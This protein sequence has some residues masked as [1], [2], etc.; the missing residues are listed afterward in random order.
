GAARSAVLPLHGQGRGASGWQ[1]RNC[2]ETPV[3][4]ACPDC[5]TLEEL[6]PLEPRSTAVCVRCTADLE[7][8]SG[9]SIDAALA[10][11]SAT[12]GLLF[13]ANLLPLMRVD[14]FHFHAQN[15]I[16]VG[17][18]EL[19]N[20]DWFLLAGLSAVLVV[21]LPFVRFS[22]L[23]AVLGAIRLGRRP[24]WLGWAFRWA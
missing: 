24:S 3:T 22:L 12:L 20:H 5:G 1:R 16:G 18:A 21:I 17:I 7:K 14:L 2:S 10:C 9:R 6:P 4:I 23:S 19:W 8:T 15:V 11:A 13:P